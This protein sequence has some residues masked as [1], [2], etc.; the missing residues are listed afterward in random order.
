MIIEFS[1]NFESHCPR[2]E[3]FMLKLVTFLNCELYAG[4]MLLLILNTKLIVLKYYTIFRQSF[5][6]V[7]VTGVIQRFFL[8]FK[9][10]VCCDPTLERSW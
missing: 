5:R 2:T 8:F 3:F 1:I 9:E 4:C 7:G 6:K 10:N